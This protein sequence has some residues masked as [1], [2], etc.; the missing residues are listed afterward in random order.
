MFRELQVDTSELEKLK[1][2]SIGMTNDDQ[3][4]LVF[5]YEKR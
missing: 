4:F 2:I 5:T 1:G 3:Q